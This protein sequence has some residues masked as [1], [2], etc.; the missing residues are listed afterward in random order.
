MECNL[1]KTERKTRIGLGIL[2]LGIAGLTML[3]EWGSALVFGVGAIALFIGA[4]ALFT[5][6]ARYCPVWRMLG[7]NI[8]HDKAAESH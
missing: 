2:F 8:F 4:I 5:G 7:I 3:P 6:V 1:G